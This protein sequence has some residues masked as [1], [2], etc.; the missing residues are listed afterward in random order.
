MSTFERHTLDNGLRVLTANLDHAQSVTCMVM[1]AAGSR[2]ETPDTN[3]IAHFSEHMFFKGTER[4]PSAR[5]IA[6]EI[7]AIGGE[8]NAFTGKEYTA[9]YVKC[10]AEHRDIALDVIVDMLRNSRFEAEEIEREKGVIIEEMNMYFDTPRDYIGG[11]YESLLYGDQPLGWDIIGRKET[12]RGATRD[13]FMSYLDHWY[14]PPRMVL[15]VAGR[16]GDDVLER[17]QEL[18]GDIP[19]AET[20]APEPARGYQSER[21]RVFTKQSDQAHLILGVPSYPLEHPD[22]YA[23]QMVAT[24]LG[25][26][27][28][29]RLF[30][31]VRE[32]RGL[33]YYVFGINH[34]YIDAGSLYSQAGVDINRIDE[35]VT[36]IA[37]ELRKIAAEPVPADELEKARNFTKGR[38]VLQLESPQGLIMFG[39]RKEVLELRAP[40]P[41]EVLA[42][43]DAVTAEDV[44]RVAQ[45]VIA[46]ERLRLALIG[47]FEDAARFEALL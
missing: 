5:D 28:S 15:G 42:G 11:V 40:D 24:V 18:L 41:E 22:R 39:L 37:S 35:A 33:A 10:A 31:E 44:Q 27:M 17:A 23:L 16:I 38:F 45:D 2:Y 29:S 46:D 32:R 43:V 30:T 3:G 26:G 8:F 21:V 47:P 14:K 6:G 34:S 25:G 13:T 1:L 20:G 12:V 7:D 9:Y 19:G 36:T 4:R